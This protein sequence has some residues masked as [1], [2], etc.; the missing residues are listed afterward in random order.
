MW[1]SDSALAVGVAPSPAHCK[2]KKRPSSSFQP[3]SLPARAARAA[4]TW[5]LAVAAVAVLVVAGAIAG[6]AW[7]HAGG[8]RVPAASAGDLYIGSGS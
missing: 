7:L 8:Q 4:A 1:H 2:G 6:R 5:L 3:R